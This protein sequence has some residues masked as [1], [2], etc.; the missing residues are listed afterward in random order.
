MGRIPIGMDPNDTD[1]DTTGKAGG[2]WAPGLKAHTHEHPH[3]HPINHDHAQIN[4]GAAGQHNHA[5]YFSSHANPGAGGFYFLRRV[6]DG[7]TVTTAT[8]SEANHDHTVNLPPYVGNS[9]SVNGSDATASTGTDTKVMPP[10][11]TIF[12][13]IRVD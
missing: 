1:F 5:G 12:Y 9:G 6:S 13:I 11:V 2:T 10:Y 4:T 7:G 8:Q 3:T